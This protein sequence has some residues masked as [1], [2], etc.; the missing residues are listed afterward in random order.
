MGGPVFA[1]V[2]TLLCLVG[3]QEFYGM[4]RKIGNA[5]APTGF[6]AVPA[7][8]L[9]AGFGGDAQALLG[10]CALAAGIPLV[11]AVFRTDLDGAFVDWSLSS[12]GA[13]YIGLPV[14]AAI[15]LRQ[16]V[17]NI[18]SNWLDDLSG[19]LAFGWEGHPRG[20]AWLLVV[21]LVTWLGDTF[22]YLVG[23]AVGRRPLIPRVSPKKTVEGLLGGLVGAA[24]TGA[25]AVALFGLGVSWWIGGLLGLVLGT[26]GV[27]G[28]LAESLIKRQA[29]VKDSGT[30]I[31]GHGGMLDRL[32]ALLFTWT[33]G[34]F[35]A[36]A[37]DR[38]V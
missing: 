7:F 30:L 15:A 29:G 14:F 18:E 38:W 17:G 23:R 27:V 35:L 11:W 24:A 16:S 37:V 19:W 33:A 6:V 34:W 22:A 20:L 3:L 36:T 5:I 12:A 26:V 10:A 28:D 21:I 13:L 4:A 9:A 2:L 25:L 31:P 1:V 8:A 32:D